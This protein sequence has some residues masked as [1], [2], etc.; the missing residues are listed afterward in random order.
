MESALSLYLP[1]LLLHLTVALAENLSS[2][3]FQKL[4]IISSFIIQSLVLLK[5]HVQMLFKSQSTPS[6]VPHTPSSPHLSLVQKFDYSYNPL[7]GCEMS[8][9]SLVVALLH[10]SQC[11]IQLY[12]STHVCDMEGVSSKEVIAVK[13]QDILHHTEMSSDMGWCKC[14][15]GCE[16]DNLAK[17]FTSICAIYLECLAL[18]QSFP[19][20]KVSFGKFW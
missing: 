9:G 3:S 7:E 10:Q 15:E 8:L 4:C 1:N 11:A 6:D 20:D 19:F 18:L 14:I 5:K 13:I 2:I 16:E 12:V 17:N